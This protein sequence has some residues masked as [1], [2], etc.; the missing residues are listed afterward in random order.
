MTD[1]DRYRMKAVQLRA[2]G[3]KAATPQ[4]RTEFEALAEAYL[5]LSQQADRNS[6]NNVAYES[7]DWL[8]KQ[9]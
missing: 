7:L 9:K 3:G 2:E 5:R 6:R 4:L 1:A 8:A